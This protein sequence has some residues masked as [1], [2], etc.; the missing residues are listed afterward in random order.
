ME[1]VCLFQTR[2]L[3]ERTGVKECNVVAK[4]M[5]VTPSLSH[6]VNSCAH[7]GG[8]RVNVTGF[9]RPNATSTPKC[10]VPVTSQK[11]YV[12][13]GELSDEGITAKD[14]ATM[15]ATADWTELNEARVWKGVGELEKQTSLQFKTTVD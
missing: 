13:F 10:W 4:C 14:D 2:Q 7:A 5:R 1:G 3:V 12:I 6:A 8:Q 15:G 9:Y 11:Y